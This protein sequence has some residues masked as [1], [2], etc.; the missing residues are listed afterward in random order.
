M[1]PMAAARLRSWARVAGA[2]AV[3]IA[4]GAVAAK[5]LTPLEP[6]LAARDLALRDPPRQELDALLSAP[7]RDGAVAALVDWLEDAGQPLLD[8]QPDYDWIE[9]LLLSPLGAEELDA[10]AAT[11]PGVDPGDPDAL[12]EA[13]GEAPGVL[14][15]TGSWAAPRGCRVAGRRAWPVSPSNSRPAAGSCEGTTGC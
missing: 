7:D 5:W 4:L 8:R 14:G 13:R 12:V 6:A 9:A 1:T 10:F 11:P 3:G 15:V 2:V